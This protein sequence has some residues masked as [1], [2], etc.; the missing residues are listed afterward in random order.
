LGLTNGQLGLTECDERQ[1]AGWLARLNAAEVL[2]DRDATP[3]ALNGARLAIT[4]RPSWQFDAAL[5]QRK[6]CEQLRV[7]SL[8]GFNAQDLPCAHAAAAALLSYAEHTQGQALAHVRHL[9]VERANSLLDLPPLT[10]RNLELTQTLRGEDSPTL[11]SLLDTCRTGMG[12]RALRHWLTHPLR[13]RR[14]ATQRRDALDVL[15][16]HGVNAIRDALRGVSDVERITARI[17]LRQVRPRE[18]TGLRATLQGLPSLRHLVP[19]GE[20][21]LLDMLAESLAP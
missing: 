17:A 18:L 21:L 11:L 5:G 1:L 9:Q 6:L 16:E 8:A 7:A 15:I 19:Q 3:A 10:H 12:S 13:E 20:A 14:V 2:V 4:P